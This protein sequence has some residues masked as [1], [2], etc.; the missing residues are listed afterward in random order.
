MQVDSVMYRT[1]YMYV[2]TILCCRLQ[3][4]FWYL[5]TRVW[6]QGYGQHLISS[7]S[8]WVIGVSALLY[9]LTYAVEF[10]K[11]K[12]RLEPEVTTSV[13]EDDD[14]EPLLI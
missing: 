13:G 9:F 4:Q 5:S 2:S 6:L 8:E 7:I 11:F 10:G 12:L 3:Q 1:S 14:A